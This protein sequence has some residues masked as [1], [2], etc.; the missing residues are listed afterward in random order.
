MLGSVKLGKHPGETIRTYYPLASLGVNIR[1]EV[2][3]HQA[4]GFSGL[5]SR[6][7]RCLQH[8]RP[9]DLLSTQIGAAI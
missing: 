8:L 7:H 9:A 5:E 3:R 2:A 1:V 6:Q 4:P